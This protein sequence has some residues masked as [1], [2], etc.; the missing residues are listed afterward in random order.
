MLR[1]TAL[2]LALAVK[3]LLYPFCNFIGIYCVGTFHCFGN[4]KAGYHCFISFVATTTAAA[5]TTTTTTAAAAASA[6]PDID[7]QRTACRHA[8]MLMNLPTHVCMQPVSSESIL[9]MKC[10]HTLVEAHFTEQIV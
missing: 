3:V 1:A 7:A 5:T 9:S 2:A 4:F 8:W 6:A 10:V